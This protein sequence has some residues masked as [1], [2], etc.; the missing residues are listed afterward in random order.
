[1]NQSGR[2]LRYQTPIGSPNYTSYA[3]LN[4]FPSTLDL[5]YS[6][7]TTTTASRRPTRKLTLFRAH[8][9]GTNFLIGVCSLYIY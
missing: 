3:S 9:S 5:Y 7:V 1:M 8:M 2:S 4:D 6:P